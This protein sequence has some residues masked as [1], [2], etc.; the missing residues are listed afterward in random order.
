MRR[1][2]TVPALLLTAL[3]LTACGDE[4]E[5]VASDP[6]PEA[7]TSTTD[8]TTEPT[9]DPT[10]PTTDPTT[11]PSTDPGPDSDPTS[12][13]AATSSPTSVTVVSAPNDS[14]PSSPSHL[15][16]TGGPSLVL[17][18]VGLLTVLAGAGVLWSRGGARRRRAGSRT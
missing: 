5:P 13:P 7:A 17:G 16:S 14:G 6:S 9:S 12:S 11:D 10:D 3:L 8:P 1:L 18:V 15:A 4:S 2:G